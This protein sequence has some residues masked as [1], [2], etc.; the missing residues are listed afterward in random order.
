MTIPSPAPCTH[1]SAMT[2]TRTAP[3]PRTHDV[4]QAR[5]SWC[6]APPSLWACLLR[7]PCPLHP[8]AR[9]LIRRRRHLPLPHGVSGL[10]CTNREKSRLSSALHLRRHMRPRAAIDVSRQCAT[11]ATVPWPPTCSTASSRTQHAHNKP[12]SSSSDSDFSS[13]NLDM[14]ASATAAGPPRQTSSLASQTP[15]PCKNACIAKLL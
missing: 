2:T 1:V 15:R 3:Q 7:R 12:S 10:R 5:T 14:V 13:Q 11:P 4:P 6:R 8:Q 9:H